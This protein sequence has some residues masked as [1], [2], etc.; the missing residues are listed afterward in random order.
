MYSSGYK[1]F[2]SQVKDSLIV[3]CVTQFVIILAWFSSAMIR[4]F[5]SFVSLE[6]LILP[7]FV[8][9]GQTRWVRCQ[10]F[11]TLIVQLEHLTL[12]KRIQFAFFIYHC[13][14]LDDK[15]YKHNVF[16]VTHANSF[17][18][19]M[20]VRSHFTLFTIPNDVNLRSN[21]FS[22]ALHKQ[23]WTRPCI[24]KGNPRNIYLFPAKQRNTHFHLGC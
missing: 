8:S 9:V 24:H 14:S 2:L 19:W 22:L 15:K 11:Y 10:P 17:Q 4:Y 23:R 16:H 21:T 3:T 18:I 6:K 12:V 5:R 1:S 20:G 7:F 13:E